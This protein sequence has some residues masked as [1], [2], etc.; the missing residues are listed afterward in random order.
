[1]KKKTAMILALMLI[2]SS[3]AGCSLSDQKD[4]EA[5]EERYQKNQELSEEERQAQFDQRV[6][7]NLEML[8]GEEPQKAEEKP[9]ETPPEPAPQKEQSQEM[10]PEPAPEMPPQ[11]PPLTQKTIMLPSEN[12]PAIRYVLDSVY[13]DFVD[14]RLEEAFDSCYDN[15]CWERMPPVTDEATGKSYDVVEFSGTGMYGGAEMKVIPYHYTFVLDGES[16]QYEY[17]NIL[18]TI[19]NSDN[20]VDEK[21]LNFELDEAFRAATINGIGH[22]SFYNTLWTSYASDQPYKM[23]MEDNGNLGYKITINMDT[24]GSSEFWTLQSQAITKDND[25]MTI[26]YSG[27]HGSSIQRPDGSI[28]VGGRREAKGKIIIGMY[29]T[30]LTWVPDTEDMEPVSLIMTK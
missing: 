12:D 20:L 16:G 30:E 11:Q 3:L 14:V 17:Y 4:M 22:R 6:Q 18:L 9:Q 19:I 1:M 2:L 10:P 24:D 29:S 7:E 28:G 8:Q 23:K 15:R 26:E 21:E 27:E 5:F 13:G 25:V